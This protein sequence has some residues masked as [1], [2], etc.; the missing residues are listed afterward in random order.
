MPL[1]PKLTKYTTASPN[2]ISYNYTDIASG[3]GYIDVYGYKLDTPTDEYIL[4]EQTTYTNTQYSNVA[5]TDIDFTLSEFK[6]AQSIK[7]PMKIRYSTSSPSGGGGSYTVDLQFTLLKN[8]V[9]VG[10][11]YSVKSSIYEESGSYNAFIEIPKTYYASGDV[12]G[13]R[14]SNA[15][16][17]TN[18]YFMHTTNDEEI[19]DLTYNPEHTIFKVSIPFKVIAQ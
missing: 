15:G 6:K 16:T 4:D 18:L 9:A 14:V 5:I 8:G 17:T 2:I 12:M 7:G 13:L 1:D 10:D 3:T 19:T 11:A